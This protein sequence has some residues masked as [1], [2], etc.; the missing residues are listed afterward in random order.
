[1]ELRVCHYYEWNHANY[2]QTSLVWKELLRTHE[3]QVIE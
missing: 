1:M 2:E 3:V